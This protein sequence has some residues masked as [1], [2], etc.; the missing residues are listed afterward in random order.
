MQRSFA[1]LLSSSE[2]SSQNIAQ[3]DI[4]RDVKEQFPTIKC[5]V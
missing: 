1:M 4:F 5:E 2:K 3:D